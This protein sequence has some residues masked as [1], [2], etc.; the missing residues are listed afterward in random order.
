MALQIIIVLHAIL[1]KIKLQHPQIQCFSA[2]AQ[3]PQ[4]ILIQVAFASP[5]IIHGKIK[6]LN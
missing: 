6:L 4:N 1:I 2:N 3:I 5:V